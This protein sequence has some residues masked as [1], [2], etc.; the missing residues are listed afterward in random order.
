MQT[1]TNF[2]RLHVSLVEM[3]WSTRES[4]GCSTAALSDLIARQINKRTKGAGP[5]TEERL[6]VRLKSKSMTK[7]GSTGCKEIQ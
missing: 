3:H 4:D 7:L 1:R 6:C 5:M 2:P